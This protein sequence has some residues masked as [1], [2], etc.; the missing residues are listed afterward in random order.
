M[1]PAGV[2]IRHLTSHELDRAA[3][4]IRRQD[5][6]FTPRIVDQTPYAQYVAKLS[7]H[8]RLL[9]AEGDAQGPLLGLVGYYCNDQATRVAYI[10]YVAVDDRQ[11]GT[12]LAA[13]LVDEA[14][15][16]MRSAGMVQVHVKCSAD[17]RGVVG[18][19]RKLGFAVIQEEALP[20]GVVKC[21]LDRAL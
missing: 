12:G 13:A 14:F 20:S 19:Y 6:W 2:T 21:T 3:E 4:F 9:A 7:A 1:R 10:S 17:I 18:F 11:R 8:G 15:A 5:H 16:D